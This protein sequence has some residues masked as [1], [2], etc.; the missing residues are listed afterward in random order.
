[1]GFIMYQFSWNRVI[2]RAKMNE[3]LAAVNRSQSGSALSQILNG[4]NG[5]D[6]AAQLELVKMINETN[7]KKRLLRREMTVA[8]LRLSLHELVAL[9]YDPKLDDERIRKLLEE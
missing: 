1:M 9:F 8:D 7:L 3:R 6:P 5:M 4:I 2:F